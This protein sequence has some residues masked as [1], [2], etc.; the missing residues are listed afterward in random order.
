MNFLLKDRKIFCV[1]HS[2]VLV[3][4]FVVMLFIQLKIPVII[5]VNRSFI[6]I[7]IDN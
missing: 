3:I 5:R 4:P 7:R 1:S 2:I 6:I